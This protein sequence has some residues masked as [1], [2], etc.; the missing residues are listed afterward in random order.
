LE[1]SAPVTVQARQLTV[2]DAVPFPGDF[3]GE[4]IF[5]TKPDGTTV[6]WKKGEAFGGADQPG[7]YSSTEPNL[8][9]AVN[10]DPSESRTTPI[11]EDQFTNLGVPLKRDESSISVIEQKQREQLLLATE[12]ESRQKLWRRLL[13]AA[14]A[15]LLVETFVARLS[16]ARV[17]RTQAA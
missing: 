2:G 13:I 15:I 10:L 3:T 9:F 17:T 12:Q 11:P 4:T 6:Q 14:L 8:L 16:L 5:L 7:F 1:Q